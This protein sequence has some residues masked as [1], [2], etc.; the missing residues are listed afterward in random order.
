VCKA[1]GAAPVDW[2]RIHARRREDVAYTFDMMR[3]EAIRWEFWTRHFNTHALE[4]ARRRGMGQVL[5][6]VKPNLA[7]IVGPVGTHKYS[8]MQVPTQQ[9]KMRTVIQYAQH[10]VAACCRKC[11]EEWHGIP[12]DHDLSDAELDYLSFL[13]Q[14]YLKDRLSRVSDV[15]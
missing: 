10:A 2:R 6:D 7:R 15:H 11:I 1:C 8:F 5:A 13:A 4:D 12:N 9:G 3:F 14:E